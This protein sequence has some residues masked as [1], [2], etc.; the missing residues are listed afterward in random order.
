MRKVSSCKIGLNGTQYVPN[1]FY[2]I[3]RTYRKWSLLFIS[4]HDEYD[5]N[6]CNETR[7]QSPMNELD[8][9]TQFSH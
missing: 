9:V 4:Y 8:I 3:Y 6:L 7:M 5:F 2:S 1:S